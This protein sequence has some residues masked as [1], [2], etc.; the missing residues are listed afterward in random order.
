LR[1]WRLKGESVTEQEIQDKGYANPDALVSTQWVADNLDDTENFRIVESDEDVILYDIGHVPNAVKIDWVEDLNDPLM[2]DYL[3][4]EH[5]ANLMADKGISPDTTVIFYGDR[6]NWWAT[7][8]LWVFRLFGHDNV[9]VMDGGR[10]KW[11]AEGRE[12]TQEVPS[13]PSAEYPV[14]TRDDSEIHARLSAGGRSQ[15]RAHSWGRERA[16]GAGC[17]GGWNLQE[18]RRVAWDIR[19]RGRPQRGGGRNSVLQDRGALLA[20]LVRALLPPRLRQG[21]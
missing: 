20:H 9:K 14:P 2:R 16:V 4:P 15:G 6:N 21:A 13:F 1:N 12:M 18:R 3:D 5:F 19:G 8:A 17:Q 10:V 7:Y 11:E